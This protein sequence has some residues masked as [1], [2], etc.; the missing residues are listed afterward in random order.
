MGGGGDITLVLVGKVGSGKSA[1][2]NSILGSNT[3]LSKYWHTSVTKTC[4]TE[5]VTLGDGC[6]IKVID[7]PGKE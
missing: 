4:Q 3:F 6:T 5:S 7:A 2:G 1:T